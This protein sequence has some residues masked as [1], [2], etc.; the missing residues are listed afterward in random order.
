MWN[1]GVKV[2]KDLAL[3]CAVIQYIVAVAHIRKYLE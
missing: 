2:E 3:V 1:V